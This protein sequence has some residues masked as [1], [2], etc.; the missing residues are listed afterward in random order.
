MALP[1]ISIYNEIGNKKVSTWLT[2]TVKAGTSSPEL[3]VHVWNNKGGTVD[4]SDMIECSVIALDKNG[5]NTGAIVSDSTPWIKVNVNDS[6]E[7]AS[8]GSPVMEMVNGVLTKKKAYHP[9]GG[10][11]T[12]PM[13]KAS[14]DPTGFTGYNPTDSNKNY[15]GY[16]DTDKKI[17][18]HVISGKVNSAIN[19]KENYARCT[20]KIDVPQNAPTATVGFKIRFQGYY[21]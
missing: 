1:E 14:A 12:F 21:V 3:T 2:G 17:E 9:I 19:Q 10:N 8:N 11:M 13:W 16:C 18:H 6:P 5:R 20:F 15:Y 7:I 4:V